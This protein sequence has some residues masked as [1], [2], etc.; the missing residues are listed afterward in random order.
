M[1]RA[2]SEASAED[3]FLR[4]RR[5][6][7]YTRKAAV[8][9]STQCIQRGVT[10]VEA[11]VPTPRLHYAVHARRVGERGD[12]CKGKVGQKRLKLNVLIGEH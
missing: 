1:L 7:I 5:Q 6:P 3:A 10:A 4:S 12:T 2:I 9:K 8:G 11:A